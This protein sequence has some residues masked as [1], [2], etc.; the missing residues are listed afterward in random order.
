M[1]ISIIIPVYNL[2][3]YI[4]ECLNSINDLNV[5][6]EIIIIN[7]GSTDNSL[8]IINE[9]VSN[10]NGTIKVLNQENGGLS[11]ARNIG[12]Q[13]ATGDYLFFLDG[14]DYIN[15]KIF[16][17]FVLD[18]VRDGV[19]IGFANY[20]YFRN[21]KI[22]KN[23]EAEYRRKIAEKTN[24][25]IDG[26]TFGERY[27]NRT[28]NFINCE[29]CFLLIKRDFL[30]KNSIQFKQG[31][32]HEDTLFTINCLIKA[33]KV[34]YYDYPFYIYRKR[35]G[36]IM[37]ITNPQKIQK[38]FKD[39]GIIALEIY[40]IKEEEHLSYTFIDTIIVDLLLVAAMHFKTKSKIISNIISTC[41]KLTLKTRI[42]VAM[43]KILSL[44]YTLG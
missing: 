4:S 31:I 11:S 21:G 41:N 36:S 19:E 38:K 39:K 13:N 2:E 24:D 18:T 9:F 28:H 5:Q 6:N 43:Y 26:L 42:R 32:Y 7:D 27:F 3:E 10:Y 17:Q 23:T 22:E 14:D 15:P 20:T 25:I 29:A 37:H 40:K 16:E 1:K 8:K 34:K 44:G 30:N 12:I 33:V 35:V